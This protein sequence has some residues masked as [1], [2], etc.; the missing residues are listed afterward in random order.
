MMNGKTHTRVVNGMRQDWQRVIGENNGK[1][2][3]GDSQTDKVKSGEL[4]Y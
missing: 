4:K 2:E 3:I 1:V